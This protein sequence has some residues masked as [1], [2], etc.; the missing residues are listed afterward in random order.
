M[1]SSID[2]DY[3]LGYVLNNM[4]LISCK[5]LFRWRVCIQYTAHL[6]VGSDFLVGAVV[7]VTFPNLATALASHSLGHIFGTVTS[8]S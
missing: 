6:F 7:A 2:L 5:N 8:H 4:E 1:V 3:T